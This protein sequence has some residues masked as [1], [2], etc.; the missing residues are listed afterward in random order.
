MLAV[1]LSIDTRGASP[2]DLDHYRDWL[3]RA[4]TLAF[5]GAVAGPGW[6]PCTSHVGELYIYEVEEA[7]R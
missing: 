6:P 7:T 1:S 3:E 2:A 4:L 5:H